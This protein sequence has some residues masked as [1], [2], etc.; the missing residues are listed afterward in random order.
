MR[1]FASSRF[2]GLVVD[3]QAYAKDL[4]AKFHDLV[5]SPGKVEAAN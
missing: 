1:S 5:G 4:K 2:R 3:V